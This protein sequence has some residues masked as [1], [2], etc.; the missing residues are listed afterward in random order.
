MSDIQNGCYDNWMGEIIVFSTNGAG[1]NGFPQVK[2]TKF[3]YPSSHYILKV[4][5]D[6]W[7][8]RKS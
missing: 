5:M 1:T 7:L 4:K 2:M 8:Q 3:G 6:Q